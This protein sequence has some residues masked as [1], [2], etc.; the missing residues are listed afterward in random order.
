MPLSTMK[1][2]KFILKYE[3]K[4]QNLYH[5]LMNLVSKSIMNIKNLNLNNSLSLQVATKK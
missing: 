1:L 3:V 2:K 5:A 4:I